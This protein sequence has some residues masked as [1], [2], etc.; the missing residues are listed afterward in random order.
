MVRDPQGAFCEATEAFWCQLP[1]Q[2]E[3]IKGFSLAAFVD[4]VSA[5]YYQLPKRGW[6]LMGFLGS[7]A[8][9]ESLAWPGL[10]L[11]MRIVGIWAQN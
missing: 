9:R 1:P 8:D 5:K 2:D 4:E 7:N 10:Q 11:L 6:N 3:E